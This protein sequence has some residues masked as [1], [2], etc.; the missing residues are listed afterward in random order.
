MSFH[1]VNEETMDDEKVAKKMNEMKQVQMPK[2]ILETIERFPKM[3]RDVEMNLMLFSMAGTVLLQQTKDLD[4]ETFY[5][6]KHKVQDFLP[7][8]KSVEHMLQSAL[9]ET[10]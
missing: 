5:R 2:E 6:I 1:H 10:K 9:D 7:V 4:S 8:L 3:A